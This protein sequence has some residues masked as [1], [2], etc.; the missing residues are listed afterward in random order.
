MK[1]KTKSIFVLTVTAFI[2]GSIIY[3]TYLLTN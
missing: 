1:E 2:C 3:L